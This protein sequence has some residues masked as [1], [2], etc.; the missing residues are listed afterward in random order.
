MVWWHNGVEFQLPGQNFV[1]G[2]SY[3]VP[4][5]VLSPKPIVD[6]LNFGAEIHAAAMQLPHCCTH[7]LSHPLLLLKIPYI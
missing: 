2:I 6:V 4:K 1:M 5:F 3:R 7:Q